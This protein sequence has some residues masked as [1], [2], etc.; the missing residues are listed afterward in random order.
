MVRRCSVCADDDD[1]NVAHKR[2]EQK[3]KQE[4]DPA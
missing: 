2:A 1:E 4:V 3:R